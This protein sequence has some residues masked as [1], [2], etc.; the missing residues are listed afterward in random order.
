MG[1]IGERKTGNIIENASGN[2]GL[3]QKVAEWIDW[4]LAGGIPNNV[5]ALHFFLEEEKGHYWKLQLRG[6]EQFDVPDWYILAPEDF[7]TGV[8]YL[9]WQMDTSVEAMQAEVTGIIQEYLQQGTHGKEF[10][11]KAGIGISTGF[12]A[13]DIIYRNPNCTKKKSA[14]L[15]AREIAK[16]AI[17]FAIGLGLSA[18]GGYMMFIAEPG[19]TIKELPNG[20]MIQTTNSPGMG[21]L[22]LAI[23]IFITSLGLYD[24]IKGN[25][26]AFLVG[27]GLVAIG[28]VIPVFHVNNV[29]LAGLGMNDIIGMLVVLLFG[30][31][32]V[33]QCWTYLLRMLGRTKQ[34]EEMDQKVGENVYKGFV[35]L[36][37][38]LDEH[39]QK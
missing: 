2:T 5:L 23:G 6:T 10:R 4:A 37:E 34:A 36:E 3:Y 13:V 25:L 31:I 24:I 39:E 11:E 20:G 12:A 9:E 28:F 8:G 22:L 19:T 30:I 33:Y 16:K 21:A 15:V 35:K 17:I 27:V 18:W 29:G 26:G 14:S 1:N 7:G 38:K 32:G